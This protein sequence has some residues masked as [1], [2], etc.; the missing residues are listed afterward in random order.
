MNDKE[1]YKYLEKRVLWIVIAGIW[2]GFMVGF[3]IGGSI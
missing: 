2:L 1:R 3:I